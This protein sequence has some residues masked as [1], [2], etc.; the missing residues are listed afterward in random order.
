MR[1]VTFNILHG[2][3]VADQVVDPDRLSVAIRRLD[4]DILALQEVDRAQPRSNLAD[5][6]EVAA[7]AMGATCRQFTA[8]ICGP[9]AGRWVPATG[10]EPPDSAAYGIA[11]LSKYPARRWAVLRLPRIPFRFPLHR[12]HPHRWDLIREEPRTVIVGDFDTPAGSLVVAATHLSFVPGWG[13]WQLRWI[14]RRLAKV[15]G[16]VVIMGDLNLTGNRPARITG[17]RS[18]AQHRTFPQVAPDRQIDHLL[19]RG[20]FGRVAGSD[21]P[22]LPLSD[23]RAL[24]VDLTFDQP[25]EPVRHD[26]GDP[27]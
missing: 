3:T 6:T 13:A 15:P 5:L 19:L 17:Y 8:A 9:P 22:D 24:V 18:L 2:R 21:A 7:S 23:H 20:H 11:L 16:P 25:D 14:R 4:P 26:Q 27:I 10:A 1:L 12:R